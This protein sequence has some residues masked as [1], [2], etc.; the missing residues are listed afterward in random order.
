MRKAYFLNALSAPDFPGGISRC[1]ESLAYEWV[2]ASFDL[3]D[4]RH[5]PW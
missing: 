4:E 3:V 5:F 1:Y 2:L